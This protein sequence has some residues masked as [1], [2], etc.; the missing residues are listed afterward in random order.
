MGSRGQSGHPGFHAVVK[1]LYI[2]KRRW[3]PQPLLPNQILIFAGSV[4]WVVIDR[5]W[6]EGCILSEAGMAFQHVDHGEGGHF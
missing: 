2:G 3:Y 5:R 1:E 4:S 6:A